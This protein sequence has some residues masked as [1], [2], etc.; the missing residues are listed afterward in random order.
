MSSAFTPATAKSA[1]VDSTT[2]ES[3]IVESAAT[4]SASAAVTAT[5]S[6]NAEADI[7]VPDVSHLVTEDDTPVDNLIQEKLQRFLVECLYSSLKL[8]VPC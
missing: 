8:D 5:A 1:T 4:N 6:D 2:M 3:A 7:P